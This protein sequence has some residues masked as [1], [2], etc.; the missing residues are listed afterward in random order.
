[1]GDPQTHGYLAMTEGKSP[2]PLES[3][4]TNGDPKLPE[5]PPEDIADRLI[6]HLRR[7]G[8]RDSRLVHMERIPERPE[9]T[10]SWPDWVNPEV[11]RVFES[12]GVASLW[13]HQ[14]DA[15]DA[16]DAGNHLVLSTGTGSGKS[17]PAWVPILSSLV[18]EAKE[19]SLAAHRSRPTCLYL[20]P[21]KALGADQLSSLNRLVAELDEPI[22]L[23]P[24]DGDTLSEAKRWARAHADI[25][26][27]NPDYLHHVLLPGHERWT[28]FL[29][30]LRYIVVDELHY[31]RGISGSHVAL[32]LR[33]L[34]RVARHLGVNPQVIML[35]ATVTDP[36][37]V[38]SAFV[39][40]G[41][42]VAVVDDGSPA[43]A[44]HLALWQPALSPA[45]AMK[46]QLGGTDEAPGYPIPTLRISP[47]TEAAN[48]ATSF[49]EKGARLLTFVR[50]RYGAEVVAEQIRER[51]SLR[52]SSS[53]GAV[54]AYR[55]GYLPEERRELERGLREGTLRA[56]A[57]TNALELGIDIAGLDATISCEWPGSRASLWQQVGRAGRAGRPGVSIL[58]AGEN[59]LD[60]YLIR[61]PEAILAEV[62]PNILDLQ[63]PHVIAPHLCC[64][65]A[66][67]PLTDSDISLFD[68]NDLTLIDQ[69]VEDGYLRRRPAGWYWNYGLES[70]PH[71]MVDI[72]GGSGDVQVIELR[73][74]A[75]IGTVPQDRADAEAHPDAI[76]LHQ[77]KTYH[78]LELSAVDNNSEQRIAVVERVTTPLRTRPS[79]HSE[80]RV[81]DEESTWTSADGL[82]TWVN[83]QTEVSSRVTDYDLLRLPHME[84]ISNHELQLPE[85]I[86]TTASTWYHLNPGAV[87]MAGIETA[88]LP[89][90]LHAAEHAAIGI[91]PL[92]ATCDRWDLGGLSIAEHTQTHRPTVFVHDAYPGGAGYAA[93]G[94]RHARQWMQRTLEAVESCGCDQGCPSC[95]QSP[96][97][98]NRN[99]PLSKKGAIALL[100]FLSK[101]APN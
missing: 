74:G 92:L 17:L 82:V 95:I 49:I 62:E 38:G 12:R 69:L 94:F 46:T 60:N 67:V 7:V 59:P 43:A 15:L 48:L 21:T 22:R 68:L 39:G 34:L 80:V 83:G 90:A 63:N 28:R 6:A 96:K 101:R 77:G 10:A 51:L 23:A 2:R 89:G 50:S 61:N 53:S 41:D 100:E 86:L 24:A 47:W 26:F 99:E 57:T 73:T 29:R 70:R 5:I 13:S 4:D 3:G 64:A 54:Q 32:V 72:R 19:T 87:S 76:Y 66:E 35:S 78:V 98:G 81:V 52:A 97:C 45:E 27:S 20:A 56:V 79:K 55:G 65:A 71:D 18:D 11:R 9:R 25:V 88:D 75:V 31:W 85:R 36:V 93:Y 8:V 58:I 1:M 84:F 33:R 16:I 30:S 44:H 40:S 42:V 91:L 14:R 37:K